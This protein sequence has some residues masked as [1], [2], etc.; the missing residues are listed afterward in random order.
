VCV[1]SCADVA[2]CPD[3]PGGA[4]VVCAQQGGGTCAVPCV[5]PDPDCPDPTMVCGFWA[6]NNYCM[7]P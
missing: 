4:A 6:G 1:E 3:N 2:D 7:W 5:N